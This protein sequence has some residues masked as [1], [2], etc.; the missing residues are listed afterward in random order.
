M[1]Q[2]YM[3]YTNDA[4]MNIFT[5]CQK[6]RMQ[7][8]MSVA[9]RRASLVSS[10]GCTPPA[11]APPVA[12]FTVSPNPACPGV[13]ITCTNTSTGA[14][15]YSWSFPGGSPASST[16]TNPTVTYATNG[17][18]T[19]TLTATNASGS[20]QAQV[21]VTVSNA[22]G[23]P[24]PF[25]EGFESNSFATNSWT[26]DNPDGG[27]TW[28][29][30]TVGGITP[31][32]RAAKMDFFNYSTTGQR[33]RMTTRTLDFTGYSQI[34]MKFDHAYRRYNTSG[35]DSL[36]VY[37]STN[38][39]GSWTRI[40][41]RGE[42]GS[43]TFATTGTSTTNFTPSQ[44]SDWCF[45]G[46]VG[47]SCYTL[48]LTPYAGN[49]AVQVRFEGFNNYG[50]NL[51]I[52]NIN[53]T[54]KPTAAF[55]VNDQTICA[56]QS[57][58]FT[59]TS[60]GNVTSQTWTFA[61]GTPSTST[62]ANPT[63]TYNTPGTYAVTLI[64]TNPSTSDTLTQTSYIT[65]AAN[66]TLTTSVNNATCGATN[67]S[68]TANPVGGGPFTYAWNTSPVQT[69][70]TATGLA[71][72]TYTVTVT[73][74]GGCT[75]TATAT[76]LNGNAPTL[77]VNSTQNA[78][79]N[80]AA[81][82]QIVASA[83]GGSGA[84]TF[85]LNG[86]SPQSNGTYT[87][88]IAGTYT[89]TA[90]DGS[91]CS[92]STQ[93]TLTQPDPIVVTQMGSQNVSCFG[94]NNGQ[95][96]L[97]ATGQGTL[98]YSLNGAT[99][100]ATG[101]FTGLV[102][103]N[104]AVEVQDASGCSIVENFTIT[105]PATLVLSL[106]GTQDAS[107]AAASNGNITVEATGGTPP[108][109]YSI[110]GN[111]NSSGVFSGVAA[112]GYTVYVTDSL[113]CSANTPAVVGT[114]NALSVSVDVTP[115]SGGQNN[116]ELTANVFGAVPPVQFIWNTSPVQFTQTVTGLGVGTY[117]VTVT[118]GTGCTVADTVQLGLISLAEGLGGGSLHIYPNPTQGLLY[119][120]AT[121]AAP[122]PLTVEVFNAVGQA[123]RTETLPS[124]GTGTATLDIG[125]LANGI[126]TLRL[127]TP[128]GIT[129]HKVSLAR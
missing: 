118:D 85:T 75:A 32:T 122:V 128:W 61:G 15:S 117:I 36:I 96:A 38:C 41:A 53:I 50:N 62:A 100:Q 66:T 107:C 55:T 52:D 70:Q 104:Y 34:T 86:G 4:C 43:G 2:N 74:A 65:V 113:G 39:G 91:G 78:T 121:F 8:V 126:Y 120:E 47:T 67:G 81:D 5:L 6:T 10:P 116:G 25:S 97:Q 19:I 115:P 30:A 11:A 123:V 72:G 29:I 1:V 63:V 33:D 83:T 77:T 103:G 71:A 98:T 73:N 49:A 106:D 105:Q 112:G 45:A 109:T 23:A 64:A 3:D 76:V 60:T 14:T 93:V 16:A 124:V 125:S 21:T 82:G 129:H 114:S 69:T 84:I 22:G 26:I 56:G 88:L 57:V 31:G 127:H 46:T 119:L 44:A 28:S 24:L 20:T 9:T 13:P 108:Y 68:A 37:I 87:G 42:N 12:S 7:T 110:P 40:L 94:A 58:N 99:P 27:I 59:N 90:T 92:N 102:P 111:I 54:G 17:T 35:T 95:I 89:L 18:Y 51:Y 48:N 101:T 80:G 79:C